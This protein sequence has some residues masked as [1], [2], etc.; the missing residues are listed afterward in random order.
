MVK[1]STILT[2]LILSTVQ[3]QIEEEKKDFCNSLIIKQ[4]RES[5]FR[6]LNFSEK[7]QYHLDLRKCENKIFVKSVRKEVNDSQLASDSEKAKT[8]TGKSSSF[9]YCI[10]LFITYLTFN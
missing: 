7:I 3:S 5:G 1:T 6:S 10:M 4:A 9:A 8:F 2:F